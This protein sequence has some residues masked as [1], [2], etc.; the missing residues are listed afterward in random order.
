M[1]KVIQMEHAFTARCI[2]DYN[3]SPDLPWPRPAPIPVIDMDYTGEELLN[4]RQ[5]VMLGLPINRAE[6]NEFLEDDIRDGI[7]PM[8]YLGTRNPIDDDL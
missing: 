5:Y 2:L 1:A 6:F 4:T 7:V 8:D 3:E